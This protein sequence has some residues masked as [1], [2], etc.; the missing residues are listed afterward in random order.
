MK[1]LILGGNGILG[2]SLSEYFQKEKIQVFSFSHSQL[3]I[4]DE[5]AV[6]REVERVRPTVIYNAGA[7]TAVEDCEIQKALAFKVNAIAPSKLAEVCRKKGIQFVHVSTDYVFDGNQNHPYRETDPTSPVNVYASSKVEGEKLVLTTCPDTLV[8]RVAWVFR[9]GGKTFLCRLKDL[10]MQETFLEVANDRVG[11]CTYGMDAAQGL[12]FLARKKAS[13]LVHFTNEGNLSWYD[14]AVALLE[15]AKELKL[16]PKCQK[17]TAISSKQLK[18]IAQRPSY[19]VLDKS[20]YCQLTGVKIRHWQE[21]IPDF[22]RE[23]I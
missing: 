17:I 2:R 3:D 19:S 9:T 16:N 10:I 6:A 20:R 15:S 12:D 23:K 22:L 11:N 4:T 18:L 21:T 1:P 13:G 14:F 8:V 5:K 7:F